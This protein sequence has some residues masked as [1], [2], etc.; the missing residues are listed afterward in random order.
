MRFFSHNNSQ[1][2]K[3][4]LLSEFGVNLALLSA[5]LFF[6]L[7]YIFS[8]NATATQGF[9][10]KKLSA[11]LSDLETQHK[12]LELQNSALQS[13]STIQAETAHLNFV[14]ASNVTYIRDDNFALK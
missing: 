9:K 3:K 14:P 4:S 10:I 12:K 11:E 8:L 7:V 2:N 13:I 5:I 6:G 1:L